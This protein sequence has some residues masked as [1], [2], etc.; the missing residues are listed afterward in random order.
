MTGRG[1][2][3]PL[4]MNRKDTSMA[5]TMTYEIDGTT[6]GISGLWARLSKAIEDYRLYRQTLDELEALNDRELADLGLSRHVLRDVANE[7][8]YG[9]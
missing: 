9:S 6:S 7:S 4:E 1:T 5:N 3:G 8:V 2:A